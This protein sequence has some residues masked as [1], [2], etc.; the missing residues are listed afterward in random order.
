MKTLYVRLVA[1][2]IV[3]LFFV[4]LHAGPAAA[5]QSETESFPTIGGTLQLVGADKD[6]FPAENMAVFLGSRKLFDAPDNPP[7]LHAFFRH[8][9]ADIAVIG[10]CSNG[11]CIYRVVEIHADGAPIVSEE[12]GFARVDRATIRNQYDAVYL[13]EHRITIRR[14]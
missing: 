6:G 12:Y 5:Q 4:L 2:A 10:M 11:G 7:A 3:V 9:R 1:S 8:S 13:G 14:P